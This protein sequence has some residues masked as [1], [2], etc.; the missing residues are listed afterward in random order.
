MPQ[1]KK[2]EARRLKRTS[3]AMLSKPLIDVHFILRLGE[4]P[5]YEYMRKH[6]EKNCRT[7]TQQM[8][9]M[10]RFAA[11]QMSAHDQEQNPVGGK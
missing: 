4:Q 11:A 6:A 3:G 2:P 10:I 1:R 7:F 9:Y 8:H 5:L